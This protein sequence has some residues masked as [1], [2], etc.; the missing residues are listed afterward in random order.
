M[1]ANDSGHINNLNE[2]QK[3]NLKEFWKILLEYIENED[4]QLKKILFLLFGLDNPDVILLRFLRARKWDIHAALEQFIQT[5][6]WRIE[7]NI[8][9]ILLYGENHIEFEEILSG[10]TFFICSDKFGRPINY[11]S[12]KDHIKGQFPSE[13]TEKLTILSMETGRKLLKYPNESVTVIF[14]MDGFAMKNMDYHHVKFLI[15]LL[16]NYYPESL[17][18]GLV[19]NAP[20]IF[21]SCWYLI[22]SWLDPVVQQK[23]HFI[24]NLQDLNQFIDRNS[25]PKRLNGDLPEFQYIPPNEQEKQMLAI[26]HQD[27]CGKLKAKEDHY[28]SGLKYLEITSKWIENK[29]NDNERKQSEEELRSSYEKLLPYISSLTHYHRNGYIN[30]PIYNQ[31]Y[32][33]IQKTNQEKTT[34]F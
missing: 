15:N 10:K 1:T 26:I 30:E 5:I 12:V 6:Q 33:F 2:N 14:D 29:S 27:S 13:S 19:L 8:E 31:T 34:F 20:W 4:D 32:E 21:N 9:D 16:Q 23:I 24:K 28:Q 7:V 25:L 11:V 3:E 18:L 22:K 17:G